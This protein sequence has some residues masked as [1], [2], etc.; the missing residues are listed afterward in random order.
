LFAEECAL[1]C[2]RLDAVF[3]PQPSETLG[4]DG[5]ATKADYVKDAARFSQEPRKKEDIVHMNAQYGAAVV[6]AVM[7][8][9][10]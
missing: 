1:A 9:L 7:P 2:L 5:L 6:A 10:L 3:V 4:G 8:V